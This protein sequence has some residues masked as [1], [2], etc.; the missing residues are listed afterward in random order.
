[1]KIINYHNVY[2]IKQPHT[3]AVLEVGLGLPPLEA[4]WTS[5]KRQK[6]EA[7]HTSPAKAETK[8]IN[9]TQWNESF[10]MFL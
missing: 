10:H 3:T 1:M 9:K 6:Y 8:K 5:R 7:A 2:D 4:K